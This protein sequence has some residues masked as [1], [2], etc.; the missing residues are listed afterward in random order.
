MWR[1]ENPSGE[2]HGAHIIL[3]T[4]QVFKL[5]RSTTPSFR[6]DICLVAIK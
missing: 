1:C 2:P 4:T 3:S 6:Q 5:F